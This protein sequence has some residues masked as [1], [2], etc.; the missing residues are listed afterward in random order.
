MST[1]KDKASAVRLVIFDIDGVLTNGGL[2]FDNQGR[3]Y[4]TF[5]SL[6][7]QGIR[8]LLECGI[9]VAII[10]GRQSDLVEHRMRDLGVELIYQGNRDKRP[11]FAELLNKTGLQASQVAYLGDDLPDLPVMSRVGLAIAVQNAH[12]F[13]KQQA[14]WETKAS[15]GTGAAREACDFILSVQGKLDAKQASYLQ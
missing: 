13:V 11:A 7:G 15:G 6:D 12:A 10:T 5:N 4:K 1:I 14:D 3:E 8:M 9:E 2:Q